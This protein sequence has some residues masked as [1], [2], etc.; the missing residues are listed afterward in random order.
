MPWVKKTLATPT[1]SILCPDGQSQ[2]PDGSTC[3]KLS[4]GEWGCCPLPKA[5]CCSDGL[6]CCPSGTTC[7]VS[8]GKCNKGDFSMPWVKKTLATPTNSILC[9]DGQSQCPDGSTCCKL[10][11]GQWGCCPLPKAACCSDGLHCCPN[12][13]TCDVSQGKCNKG[14]FSMPWV[15]KTLATPTNSILCPD[16]QSQCP[17]GSTCCKLSTGEWGCCPLPKAVCCSD[18]LHCCPSGTTCD[19]SQGK[20]NKGDFSMPWVKKTLATPTNSILCPDGQSQCPDGSTC[21]KLSTGQWGCCPLPKFTNLSKKQQ[22]S[23]LAPLSNRAYHDVNDVISSVNDVISSVNDVTCK[24]GKQKCP[25]GNTC[26]EEA[27]GLFGCCPFPD[28]VCC[29]D[30]QHCCPQGFTCDLQQTKCIKGSLGLPLMKK[31]MAQ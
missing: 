8:Q 16:G 23:L 14:D 7:D 27:S 26:C 17:D 24:G 5:V 1:N 4:T 20:C 15:K 19:V 10:S 18:G 11:T 3:C 22:V 28:A 29:V 21:C 12:G 2:C 13:T 9:P 30:Q 25:D 31:T 6:H